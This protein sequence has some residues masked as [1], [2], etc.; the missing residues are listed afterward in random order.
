M[1]VGRFIGIIVGPYGIVA[2]RSC[3]GVVMSFCRRRIVIM[4]SHICFAFMMI[5]QFLD[6]F[7]DF[8]LLND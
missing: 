4:R 8:T 2:M 1:A 5:S 6:S 7:I 3:V